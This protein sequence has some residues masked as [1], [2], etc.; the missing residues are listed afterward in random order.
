MKQGTMYAGRVKKAFAKAR[1]STTSI[2]APPLDNPL[3]RLCQA[4]FGSAVGDDR[5]DKYITRLLNYM[6]DW[7]EVRV[8]TVDEI[9]AAIGTAPQAAK[10]R[11]RALLDVL[12]AVYQCENVLSLD[13]LHD[14]G[15]RDARTYL[16]ALKGIDDYAVASVTLWSLGGHAIPVDDRLLEA[17]RTADLVHP[18]ATRGEVQAF[19]ERH[20]SAADAKEFFFVMQS[21]SPIKKA[22]SSTKKKKTATKSKRKSKKAKT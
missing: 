19:L 22:S 5:G 14:M 2:E 11:C 3:N 9:E 10:Q 17:L 16:E 15:R 18:Q 4:I 13:R 8:S 20:I 12:G 7:N 21:F 1:A 6:V